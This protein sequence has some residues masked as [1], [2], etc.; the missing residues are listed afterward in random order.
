[1]NGSIVLEQN[2][3]YETPQYESEVKYPLKLQEG[4]CFVLG[5][6]REGATDSRYFGAVDTQEIRGKIIT[7]IRR[8]QL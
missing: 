8:N 2:I 5:D 7:V 1:M 6:H 3:F 4:E